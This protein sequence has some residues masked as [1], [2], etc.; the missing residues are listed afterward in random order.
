MS[1]RSESPLLSVILPVYNTEDYLRESLDALVN[2]T[3]EDMEFICIND[4]SSDRS[5][6]ILE[7]YAKK[8]DR[9]F[10][11]NNE[12]NL[13]PSICRNMALKHVNGKYVV[14]YDSDDIIDLDAYERLCDFADKYNQDFVLCNVVRLKDDGKVIKSI[15]HEH[16]IPDKII[17]KT[18]ILEYNDF[19]YD[20]T[21]WNKIIRRE[22][23][24][25]HNFQFAEGRVYQDILFTMQ[26]FCA[27]DCVGIYPDV[28]YYWRRRGNDTKSITQK[29]FSTKNLKDRM[30]II[31]NTLD[32][33]KSD[34]AHK[35]ILDAFYV[36]LI[37]IDLVKF[38]NQLDLCDDEFK[39]LLFG[40]V[41]DFVE[42]IPSH[43]FNEISSDDMIKVDLYLNKCDDS[44]IAL[45]KHQRLV[46]FNRQELRDKNKDLRSLN[47]DLKA[48]NKKLVKQVNSLKSKNEK[49]E[50]DCDYLKSV[51]RWSKYKI[52]HIF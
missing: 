41:R 38:I 45:A 35:S 2:Q 4:G 1:D 27:S 47:K 43:V 13:G 42:T 31:K 36:K 32:V 25:S 33:I 23:L 34:E 49:L 18:N 37:E 5:L 40:R 14:F 15:L 20:T 19:V 44:L 48:E 52:R 39:E 16:S 24:E 7:E 8:D 50:T 46:K 22:F 51:S 28:K 30:F 17:P 29:P 3:L 12:T 9:F 10:I 21:L 26:M 11:I 6:E